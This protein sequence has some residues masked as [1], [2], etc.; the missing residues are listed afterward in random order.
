M[1]LVV[2]RN[3]AGW[4]GVAAVSEPHPSLLLCSIASP[5]LGSTPSPLS[6][7]LSVCLIVVSF[8]Q[9]V[10]SICSAALQIR[11]HA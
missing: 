1:Y 9:T 8:L 6:V 10:V 11:K 2:R 7:S 3:V 4:H 5:A